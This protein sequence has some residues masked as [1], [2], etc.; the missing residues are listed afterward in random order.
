MEEKDEIAVTCSSNWKAL[1]G[2]LEESVRVANR[3]DELGTPVPTSRVVLVPPSEESGPC[4]LTVSF[5][6]KT[7]Y[8][9]E[10]CTLS[11]AR[12]VEIYGQMN[13]DNQAEYVST[14]RGTLVSPSKLE[15]F[16][17]RTEDDLRMFSNA[18][19]AAD[20]NTGGFRL[21]NAAGEE[22][23]SEFRRDEA[24]N[25]VTT[26]ESGELV[27]AKGAQD[28]SFGGSLCERSRGSDGASSIQIIEGDSSEEMIEEGIAVDEP[29]DQTDWVECPHSPTKSSAVSDEEVDVNKCGFLLVDSDVVRKQQAAADRRGAVSE[30]SKSESESA[31][32]QLSK[33]PSQLE[34]APRGEDVTESGIQRVTCSEFRT[35]PEVQCLGENA[36]VRQNDVV[37]SGGV[38]FTGIEVRSM[39]VNDS[40]A[41]ASY[42]EVPAYEAEAGLNISDPWRSVKIRFLSLKDKSK[43]VLHKVIISMVLGPSVSPLTKTTGPFGHLQPSVGSSS[44]LSMLA[45][46]ILQMARGLGDSRKVSSSGLKSG[47]RT[48]LESEISPSLDTTTRIPTPQP[49]A[50]DASSS[51]SGGTNGRKIDSVLLGEQNSIQRGKEIHPT[52]LPSSGD[53]P[54]R[55]VI[56]LGKNSTIGFHKADVTASKVVENLQSEKPEDVNL[57]KSHDFSHDVVQRLDR[58]EA[59]CLRIESSL[60]FNLENIDRRLKILEV[61]GLGIRPGTE[62]PRGSG[63]EEGAF[64]S[65]SSVN[66]PPAH[67]GEKSDS[68][69]DKQAHTCNSA[70]VNLPAEELPREGIGSTASVSSTLPFSSVSPAL[71]LWP[72][73][74][75]V[76]TELCASGT[77][78]DNKN[79]RVDQLIISGQSQQASVKAEEAYCEAQ[80]SDDTESDIS[81]ESSSTGDALELCSCPESVSSSPSKSVQQVENAFG[82]A[83]PSFSVP[84]DAAEFPKPK[85]SFER[86]DDDSEDDSFTSEEQ[87]PLV[88]IDC[89]ALGVGKGSPQAK[90]QETLLHGYDAIPVLYE[91]E[92]NDMT[93]SGLNKKD[94]FWA[95]GVEDLENRSHID[96]KDGLFGAVDRKIC[97]TETDLGQRFGN[98]SP[99]FDSTQDLIRGMCVPAAVPFVDKLASYDLCPADFERSLREEWRAEVKD[100][101]SSKECEQAMLPN[102]LLEP[103][104]GG[105]GYIPGRDDYWCERSSEKNFQVEDNVPMTYLTVK[106]FVIPLDPR[107]EM[108]LQEELF[109]E[110][111]N[112]F[113]SEVRPTSN[114]GN[115]T[116]SPS[117]TG[118]CGDLLEV[119]NDISDRSVGYGEPHSLLDE[120]TALVG[121]SNQLGVDVYSK[122]WQKNLCSLLD[123]DP[124][125]AFGVDFCSEEENHD[126]SVQQMEQSSLLDQDMF[127]SPRNTTAGIKEGGSNSI[128]CILSEEQYDL[129]G[130]V[131][132][133]KSTDTE[134][135]PSSD[136][137]R[138]NPFDDYCKENV[139]LEHQNLPARDLL[140][141]F[142]E[143]SDGFEAPDSERTQSLLFHLSL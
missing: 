141:D 53:E 44:F 37:A 140:E 55:T 12:T 83:S 94:V 105:E 87:V 81:S 22:A 17:K 41:E 16:E 136:T 93:E 43:L 47:E 108:L 60:N 103:P 40:E 35:V 2:C 121:H 72:F 1:E 99:A 62:Q 51:S 50:S 96:W 142:G 54:W 109:P 112:W 107:N 138:S 95:S 113:S 31:H 134:R 118:E 127:I 66:L 69:L 28:I 116:G 88:D 92:S 91:K 38:C 119:E 139:K 57:G 102:A 90:T 8:V 128:S 24:L 11:S 33:E 73:S 117:A 89:I 98:N 49:T 101:K 64:V 52:G 77:S 120:E 25:C 137:P 27:S 45:P 130:I 32:G 67:R 123:A 29:L 114:N 79:V 125:I 34:T 129:F 10:L 46:G 86:E 59:I 85:N 63:Y 13:Q 9:R 70:P 122:D 71:P 61:R 100:G 36:E 135:S 15:N 4:E 115:L 21:A 56:G 84:S 124:P 18:S 80:T 68:T 39:P 42:S 97:S 14:V 75:R 20:G 78:T 106:D 82:S 26:V 132:L 65:A 76:P 126:H 58:L 3:S 104:S 143:E 74:K 6:R 23:N 110:D 131:G 30:S 111:W 7:C 133:P 5:Q 48:F 19:E